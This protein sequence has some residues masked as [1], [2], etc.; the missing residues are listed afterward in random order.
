MM[1]VVAVTGVG[2][3]GVAVDAG[4]VRAA[5]DLGGAEAKVGARV[6][7]VLGLVVGFAGFD[8]VTGV[9]GLFCGTSLVYVRGLVCVTGLG[10]E[11]NWLSAI[12][13]VVAAVATGMMIGAVP[14]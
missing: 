2:I 7:A 10:I 14:G 4:A 3:A 6:A 8:A 9:A 5:V 1:G 13:L 11:A 12:G